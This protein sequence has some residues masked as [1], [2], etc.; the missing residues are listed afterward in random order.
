MEIRGSMEF[1]STAP[2]EHRVKP[3][4]LAGRRECAGPLVAMRSIM[5]NC[6]S[7]L[8][9]R[10][11][12]SATLIAA[13]TVVTPI[14]Q[15]QTCGDQ[16]LTEFMHR[17]LDRVTTGGEGGLSLS[18]AIDVRE[19][20]MQVNLRDAWKNVT[21]LAPGLVFADAVTGNVIYAGG[22]WKDD[23][24]MSMFQRLKIV[25]GKV[26]ESEMLLR[27]ARGPSGLVNPDIVYFASVPEPRRS[28]RQQLV[29]I[30]N[31]YMDG[32]SAGDGSIPSFD[33]RCDR[34]ISGLKLTNN[35]AN[36]RGLVTCATSLNGLTGLSVVHR[37]FV[38]ADAAQGI[39][40][41]IFT[42]VN[43]NNHQTPNGVVAEIF[44]I[45]DGNIRSVEEFGAPP[46]D[47]PE[48]AGFPAT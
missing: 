35:P 41:A 10:I 3:R 7:R 18:P 34:Y 23:V 43:A 37:R 32:I 6:I 13:G 27:N 33:D 2:F 40:A 45:V 38:I 25:A 48:D 28:S 4:A 30:A 31:R 44:K 22:V 8:S 17:Y 42:V 21:K 20:T 14:G 26:T 36:A 1:G 15:A 12:V 19:N 24:L 5:G 47:Y 46:G 11:L 16:C 9:L 39:V 29:A